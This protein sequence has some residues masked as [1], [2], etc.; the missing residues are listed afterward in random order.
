VWYPIGLLAVNKSG[1]W[2]GATATLRYRWIEL[3]TNPPPFAVNTLMR[4]ALTDAAYQK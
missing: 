3:Y 2:A 4:W 1:S